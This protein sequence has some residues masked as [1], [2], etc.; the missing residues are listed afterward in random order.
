[1][2]IRR[3]VREV[4]KM[5]SEEKKQ[6]LIILRLLKNKPLNERS[7]MAGIPHKERPEF[8]HLA[9]QVRINVLNEVIR[10]LKK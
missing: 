10:T 7:L 6:I 1:M 4:K 3:N 2:G 8:K 5:I 9:Q